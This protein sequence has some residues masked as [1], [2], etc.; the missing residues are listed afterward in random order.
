[1]DMIVPPPDRHHRSALVQRAHHSI[2]T[3]PSEGRTASV[4]G[5]LVEALQEICANLLI[6]FDG[7]GLPTT[8]KSSHL[9][10][11]WRAT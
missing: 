4:G 6:Y 11:A 9:Y 2:A 5:K 10:L 8:E 3:G 7:E 1:M